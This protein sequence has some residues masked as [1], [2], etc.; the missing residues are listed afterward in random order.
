MIIKTFVAPDLV[1]ARWLLNEELGPN[2]IVLRTRFNNT[3]R[4]S[5]KPLKFV[6]ITAALD[7]SLFAA[8]DNDHSRKNPNQMP[9]SIQPAVDSE[10]Q[11][12]CDICGHADLVEV[13][14]W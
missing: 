6:E 2:S 9:D 3:R 5:A 14:G 8:R 10:A 13:I 11:N 12:L 1:R 4:K 7:S